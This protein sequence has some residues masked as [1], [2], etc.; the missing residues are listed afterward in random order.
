[1][2]FPIAY[3][4][5]LCY[6]EALLAADSICIEVKENFPKQTYRNRTDI[7]TSN[8]IQS[9]SIPV[10]RQ[11][12]QKTVVEDICVDYTKSWQNDHWRAI[13]S[14]YKNAPYFDY[15]G[16]EVEEIIFSK[17][18]KLIDLNLLTLQKII[19]WLDLP[20]QYT[21]STEF[22]VLSPED[23]RQHI[24]SKKNLVYTP[25]PYIQTFQSPSSFH[26]KVSILDGIFCEGPTLRK[27][28]L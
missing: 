5:S 17:H 23:F 16:V 19:S 24:L 15:Y 7:V 1:M 14:A 26:K 8:G 9:L 4:G 13:K 2:N 11:S 27:I 3:F 10:I 25:A 18:E 22:E 20:I 28:L 6:F 21:L 12:G